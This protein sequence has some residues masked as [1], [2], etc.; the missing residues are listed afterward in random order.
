M[1]PTLPA[2][3]H[4]VS[5]L[6]WQ[7]TGVGRGTISILDGLAHLASIGSSTAPSVAPTFSLAPRGYQDRQEPCQELASSDQIFLAI[8]YDNA[9]LATNIP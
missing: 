3:K 4:G 5:V 9:A 1:A 6:D 8:T 2:A 7:S